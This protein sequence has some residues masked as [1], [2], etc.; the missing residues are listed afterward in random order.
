LPGEDLHL[1]EDQ[2]LTRITAHTK[3]DTHDGQALV[4]PL[5]DPLL[6]PHRFL[7][8]SDRAGAVLRGPDGE[9][10]NA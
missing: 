5:D 2:H 9:R 8:D 10:V 1:T 3:A 4:R 6:G 7:L